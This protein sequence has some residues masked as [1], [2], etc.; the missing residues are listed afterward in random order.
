[1][2]GGGQLAIEWLIHVHIGK[3]SVSTVSLVEENANCGEDYR[4]YVTI[5]IGDGIPATECH[6]RIETFNF[7][8]E[9]KTY[10]LFWEGK[11]SDYLEKYIHLDF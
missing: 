8:E 1:M 6:I 7:N 5:P 11:A 3:E 9:T 4:Y 2:N 10:E